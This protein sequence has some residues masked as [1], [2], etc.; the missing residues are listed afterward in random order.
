MQRYE[1][2]LKPPKNFR[3]FCNIIHFWR[4]LETTNTCAVIVKV[5]SEYFF[6]HCLLGQSEDYV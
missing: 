1:Y 4:G 3:Y 5:E 2:Y 6:Y